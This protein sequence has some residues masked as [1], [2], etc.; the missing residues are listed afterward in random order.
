MSELQFI[1]SVLKKF[2][3]IIT[4]RQIRKLSEVL[5]D[6]SKVLIVGYMALPFVTNTYD[7]I[8]AIRSFLIG[9][10]CLYFGLYLV[11]YSQEKKG[12]YD[13]A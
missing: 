3:I 1:L 7:L 12:R 13:S 5:L 2:S 11:E 6:V 4:A 8:S 10:I 9:L